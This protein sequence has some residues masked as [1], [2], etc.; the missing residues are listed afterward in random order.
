MATS[1]PPDAPSSAPPPPAPSVSPL[2]MSPTVHPHSF[3][4]LQLAVFT[5][6]SANTIPLASHINQIRSRVI[7]EGTPLLPPSPPAHPLPVLSL[8][9]DVLVFGLQ[10][11]FIKPSSPWSLIEDPIVRL[12][13]DAFYGEDLIQVDYMYLL[14]ITQVCTPVP[15]PLSPVP[16]PLS[17]VPCPLSPVPCPLSPVPCPLSLSSHETNRWCTSGA[18]LLR[19]TSRYTQTRYGRGSRG[20]WGTRARSAQPSS[21]APLRSAV[22]VRTSAPW[23][24]T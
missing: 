5:W 21:W 23:R 12:L 22:C 6:N 13:Q 24:H 7:N 4:K 2:P 15:C 14:G 11:N 1:P 3:T 10:E 16:C 8:G 18:P 17:P 19:S 9:I 20:G